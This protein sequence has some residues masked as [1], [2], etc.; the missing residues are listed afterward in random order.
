MN[1][2]PD[3]VR[4]FWQRRAETGATRWTADEFFLYEQNVLRPHVA[5]GAS[6]LDLG[7]GFGELSRSICPDSGKLTA[8]DLM[9]EYSSAFEEDAR[10]VFVQSSVD[11]YVPTRTFDVVLLFGVVTHL[12]VEQEQRTYAVIRSA[13]AEGGTAFIKNQCSDDSDLWIDTYSE[14][15]QCDYQ[16]RYPSVATQQKLLRE[17]FRLVE[18][19]TYPPNLKTHQNTSHVLFVCSH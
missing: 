5:E 17:K 1:F 15:L 13:L 7:S 11:T 19:I 4:S 3:F 16:A 14:A 8:V 18:S 6:I 10:Y 12:T 2:K 9:H